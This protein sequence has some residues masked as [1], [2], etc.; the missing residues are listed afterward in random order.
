MDMGIIKTFKT[1][2]T[3]YKL[4]KV[5]DMIDDG[6]DVFDSYKKMTIVDAII[7]SDLA[8]EEISKETIYNCFKHLKY[9]VVMEKSP[10]NEISP[11]NSFS[12]FG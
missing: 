10:N 8:W 9:G 1:H 5:I 7:Y 12:E 6:I 11:V 4:K 3:R 2:Y